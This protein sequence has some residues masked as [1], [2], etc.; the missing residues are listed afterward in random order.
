MTKTKNTPAVTKE[1]KNMISQIE[2]NVSQDYLNYLDCRSD[3][4]E[5]FWGYRVDDVFLS[6]MGTA[7]EMLDCYNSKYKFLYEE[8]LDCINKNERAQ[9]SGVADFVNSRNLKGSCPLAVIDYLSIKASGIVNR[10]MSVNEGDSMYIPKEI[11][12]NAHP[13]NCVEKKGKYCFDEYTIRKPLNF[14]VL[15]LLANKVNVTFDMT[16]GDMLASDLCFDKM[17][18]LSGE[19]MDINFN[20]VS[21]CFDHLTD[22]GSI[23]FETFGINDDITDEYKEFKDSIVR[24]NYLKEVISLVSSTYWVLSKVN[25]S[26]DFFF[27][28][29]D[30]MLNYPSNEDVLK[31]YWNREAKFSKTILYNELVLDINGYY[32]VLAQ[33]YVHNFDT[34]KIGSDENI[35]KITDFVS[36]EHIKSEEVTGDFVLASAF[37]DNYLNCGL[38]RKDIE[39][40]SKLGYLVPSNC[41]IIARS[42]LGFRFVEVGNIDGTLYAPK[43]TSCIK[44]KDNN[45]VTKE[46]LLK[47]LRTKFV[48]SQYGAYGL[49]SIFPMEDLWVALP[50]IKKQMEVISEESKKWARKAEAERQKSFEEYKLDIR[51]KKHSLGQTLADMNNWL[52][53]LMKNKKDGI[54]D[55]K[56]MVGKTRPISIANVFEK[57]QNDMAIMFQK[58]DAFTLGDEME[59]E[60]FEIVPFI[61][62]FIAKHES[63]IFKFQ[64]EPNNRKKLL[65]CLY[66]DF[67]K[68]ALRIILENIISNAVSHGFD[69]ENGNNIVK[70]ELVESVYDAVGY[71]YKGRKCVYEDKDII[72]VKHYLSLIVSN[73]GKPLAN[74]MTQEKMVRWGET[75]NSSH[76]GIGAFQIKGLW[77]KF[78]KD[79]K[80]KSNIPGSDSFCEENGIEN[81][82]EIPIFSN[83][84]ENV[85]DFEIVSTPEDEFKVSYKFTFGRE[86][87]RPEYQF[88]KES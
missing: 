43:N 77:E 32:N 62:D 87:H 64:F 20:G 53:V 31:M 37:V 68:D 41:I 84:N 63:P 59:K 16:A 49:K 13:I 10:V 57:I 27:V 14:Y 47:S 48:T 88:F 24:N 36:I 6:I 38:K 80:D 46:Y 69:K 30:Y 21:K 67:S 29:G 5:P 66:V 44:F 50:D 78:S 79:K 51:M 1:F 12:D 18:L 76:S 9:K 83:P 74:G 7:Y 25:T 52:N 15:Y 54:L 11:F 39:M 3:L 42:L 55:D 70:F 28:S 22:N 81:I 56:E 45:V 35:Y 34:S 19:T 65:K 86:L 8:A 17:F 72:P 26:I 4:E 60:S 82:P 2:F 75:T 71:N 58:V 40:R 33:K 85:S 73:N 61:E 23:I